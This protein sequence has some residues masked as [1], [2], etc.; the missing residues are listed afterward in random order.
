MSNKRSTENDELYASLGDKNN[1]K[2][3]PIRDR[4]LEARL[5][6]KLSQRDFGGPLGL[7]RRRITGLER[8]IVNLSKL[9]IIAFES[10]HGIS[11]KW[12]MTGQGKKFIKKD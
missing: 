3:Q 4:M 9:H 2:K 5:E 7:E 8:G 10:V 1:Y 12:I 11:Q 6:L